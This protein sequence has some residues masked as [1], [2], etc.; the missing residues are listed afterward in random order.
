MKLT[1]L[2]KLLRF[3]YLFLK[4]LMELIYSLI[5][6]RGMKTVG[7]NSSSGLRLTGRKVDIDNYSDIDSLALSMSKIIEYKRS[8]INQVINILDV[9]ANLG[10]YSLAF[11]MNKDVN[12]YAFEP[13]GESFQ[14]LISNIENNDF[15]NINPINQGLSDLNE[16]LFLGPPRYKNLSTRF[17]KYFDKNSLGSRTIHTRVKPK[18]ITELSDFRIGD[19]E[20]NI[21]ALSS[22]DI[23]K[24]DVEGSEMKV[25]AGLKETIKNYHPAIMIEINNNY[26]T[27]AIFRFLIDSGYSKFI[28]FSVLKDSNIDSEIIDINLH[29]QFLNKDKITLDLV[30]L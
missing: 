2:K 7:H 23:I 11:G 14:Y 10:F 28:D 15:H 4:R 9:G 8:S 6:S 1:Y 24:I 22:V 26:E 16:K 30:F 19:E 17:L 5:T 13:F 25:L 29:N 12:I 18:N 3:I 21:L 27:S 20:K